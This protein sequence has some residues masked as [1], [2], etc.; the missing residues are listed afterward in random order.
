MPSFS[1]TQNYL[2]VC[3]DGYFMNEVYISF[4]LVVTWQ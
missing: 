2:R 1:L 4:V 3:V